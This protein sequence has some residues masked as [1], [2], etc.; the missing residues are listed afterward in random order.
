MK[1][2]VEVFNIIIL[3]R[4]GVRA[5]GVVTVST[6]P[7]EKKEVKKGQRELLRSETGDSVNYSWSDTGTTRNNSRC[8]LFFPFRAFLLSGE[9][10][11]PSS[12]KVRGETYRA[13]SNVI[14]C[15]SAFTSLMSGVCAAVANLSGT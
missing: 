10:E 6:P 3:Q 15:F 5:E 2:D 13:K 9:R 11:R 1:A 8:P 12:L 4:R 7:S 14:S